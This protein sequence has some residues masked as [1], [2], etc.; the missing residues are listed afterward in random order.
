MEKFLL[1]LQQFS[2]IVP[3]NECIDREDCELIE[4]HDGQG[5]ILGEREAETKNY[6]WKESADN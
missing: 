3:C 5:C 6:F 2:E 1:A 4:E